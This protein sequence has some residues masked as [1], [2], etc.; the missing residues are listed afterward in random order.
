MDFKA[1]VSVKVLLPAL[2]V[3]VLSGTGSAEIVKGTVKSVAKEAKALTLQTSQERVLFLQWDSKTVWRGIGKPAEIYPDEMLTADIRRQG[4]LATAVYISRIKPAVPA[5]VAALQ[6]DKLEEILG[7]PDKTRPLVL[8]DT[9]PADL[10]DRAHIPGA[11]SLPLSRLEKRSFGRLP[12][13]RAARLIFY[14]EGQ[15]GESAARG[16][17]LAVKAGFTDVSILPEGAAGWV[18]AGK[19]LASTAM[20]IRKS[21]PV[22]IDLR[23]PEAVSQGHIEG[24]VNFPASELKDKYGDF[25]KER[26]V[27]IVL[28]GGSDAE[29]VAAAET[30]RRWGYRN[31]TIFPGGVEA[32]RNSAEVILTGPAESFI[33]D[34]TAAHGGQ[35]SSKDFQM[36]L[37][38]SQMVDIVD[39]RSSAGHEKGGFPQAKKIPLQDLPR[40]HG[41]LNREKIQVVFGSNPEYAE[42]AYDFLKSYGYRVNYLNGS[43][44]FGKEGKYTVK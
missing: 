21:K 36:A 44:E 14:D 23:R 28:Y 24:A 32:W 37:I 4:T 43:V 12:E 7:N 34:T 2:F 19:V 1:G 22:I 29:A 13:N 26:R 5:G 20:F 30:V 33:S 18:N 10:F 15:G 11:L 3:A 38:S 16:A 42:M 40:R 27:P 31:V 41:E 17:E 8:V 6:L 25:L 9:R 39:T 35:L